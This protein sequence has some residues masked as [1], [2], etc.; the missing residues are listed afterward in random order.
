MHCV[1]TRKTRFGLGMGGR[2]GIFKMKI[3]NLNL[4]P[5]VLKIDFGDGNGKH[6]IIVK[7]CIMNV[8]CNR[9]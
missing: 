5:L 1:W 9:D 8:H 6:R 3:K 4:N 2:V 7:F